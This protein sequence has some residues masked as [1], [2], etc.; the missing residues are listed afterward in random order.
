MTNIDFK[1]HREIPLQYR[2]LILQEMNVT[3]VSKVPLVICNQFIQDL[4]DLNEADMTLMDYDVEFKKGGQTRMMHF[5]DYQSA[6]VQIDRVLEFG[7]CRDD[8]VV[9]AL[10]QAKKLIRGYVAGEWI[11]IPERDQ[12]II[13]K[14]SSN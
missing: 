14:S 10:Y 11:G 8:S 5:S 13:R 9:I 4:V 3:R 7:E 1:N 6:L 2:K 12:L